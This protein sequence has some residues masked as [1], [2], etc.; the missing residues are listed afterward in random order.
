MFVNNSYTQYSGT[1][2]L[3]RHA[4][5]HMLYQYR[6]TE[7]RARV[8]RCADSDTDYWEIALLV[9]NH[10]THKKTQNP[11]PKHNYKKHK[12]SNSRNTF[13]QI[14]LHTTRVW[15]LS[16]FGAVVHV[17]TYVRSFFVLLLCRC[18]TFQP[19]RQLLR[20]SN[21]VARARACVCVRMC[22]MPTC[23]C[24]HLQ[25]VSISRNR[26]M[27][28]CVCICTHHIESVQLCGS[29]GLRGELD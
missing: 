11:N 23:Y 2:N 27:R 6:C 7:G 14:C 4:H 9:Y 8:R 29:C 22:L 28:V 12:H 10:Q 15:Q 16:A 20:S 13:P 1:V 17:R 3:K 5:K 25:C 24:R 21:C 18:C 19:G 26:G